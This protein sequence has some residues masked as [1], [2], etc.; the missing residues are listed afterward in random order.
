MLYWMSPSMQVGGREAGFRAEQAGLHVRAD[1]EHRGGGAMVGA[2][3]CRFPCTR[4]PNSLKVMIITRS[5]CAHGGQVIGE[6]LDGVAEFLAAG[7]PA[8]S[9]WLVCVS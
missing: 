1:E 8:R 2:A 3:G 6:G 5:K 9:R 4:R 7:R